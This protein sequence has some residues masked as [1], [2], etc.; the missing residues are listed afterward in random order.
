MCPAAAQSK[1]VLCS[2]A[3]KLTSHRHFHLPVPQ[4]Q[5]QSTAPH[6]RLQASPSLSS[7]FPEPGRA[8]QEV[9][10]LHTQKTCPLGLCITT[11][12]APEPAV[13]TVL[14]IH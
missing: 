9:L 4:E 5:V 6:S 7:S 13:Q 14:N 2:S 8:Q 3:G 11:G 12:P 10:K 1:S